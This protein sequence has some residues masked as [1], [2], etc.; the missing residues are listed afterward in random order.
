MPEYL[1]C[2]FSQNGLPGENGI[3]VPWPVVVVHSVDLGHVQAPI[4]QMHVL[5]TPQNPKPVA[6]GN[7]PVRYTIYMK[8][9]LENIY[10]SEIILIIEL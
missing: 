10:F 7:V 8:V 9:P 4:L 6:A 2:N 5:D 3:P 1:Q